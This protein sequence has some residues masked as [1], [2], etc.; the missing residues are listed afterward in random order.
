MLPFCSRIH[1]GRFNFAGQ[2]VELAANFL[3]EPHTIHG[4]G[5]QAH[6]QLH[7]M[8]ETAC[9]LQFHHDQAAS[10]ATGWPWLFSAQQ[11]FELGEQGLVVTVALENHSD[12]VMPAGMGLHPH[13]PLLEATAGGNAGTA[14]TLL[15]NA[16]IQ[17]SEAFLPQAVD[18][19][20]GRATNVMAAKPW[21]ERDVDD[22]FAYGSGTAQIQWQE[23]P[24][25]VCIEADPALPHWIVFA[26]RGAGFIC[27]EPISHFPNVVN[28][29]PAP[30]EASG[31]LKKLGPSEVWSTCTTFRIVPSAAVT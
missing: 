31:G 2:G 10:D 30:A 9:T 14:I 29:Q 5:W 1:E 23:K 6:W 4:F 19:S 20:D 12:Q 27:I 26:P 7:S 16:G 3:P 24:W 18:L 15:C 17:M 11:R 28:V 8:S 25:S 21:R 22:V 13:F